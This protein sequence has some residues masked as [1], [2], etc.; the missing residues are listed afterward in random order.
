[1]KSDFI[2][3]KKG[4]FPINIGIGE[5]YLLYSGKSIIA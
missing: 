2:T 1:M 4:L 3:G 5:I